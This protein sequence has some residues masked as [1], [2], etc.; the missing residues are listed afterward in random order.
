[1]PCGWFVQGVGAAQQPQTRHSIPVGQNAGLTSALS[2]TRHTLRS[3]ILLLRVSDE[4]PDMQRRG[5]PPAASSPFFCRPA[6]VITLRHVRFS[7]CPVS[8]S[9]C[10][11]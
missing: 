7:V 2:G 6:P 8:L 9:L 10:A 5:H 3:G 1:M 11:L 4:Q